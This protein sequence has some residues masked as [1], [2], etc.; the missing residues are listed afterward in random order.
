M[1]DFSHF[2]KVFLQKITRRETAPRK[3][4]QESPARKAGKQPVGAVFRHA[5]PRPAAP[6]GT[7]RRGRPATLTA[8][9]SRGGVY[10]VFRGGPR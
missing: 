8:R 7:N 3:P 2:G 6:P 4:P 10:S 5:R 1:M 9:A